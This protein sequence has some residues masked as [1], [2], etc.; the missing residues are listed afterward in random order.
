MNFRQL[1]QEEWEKQVSSFKYETYQDSPFAIHTRLV[2][3]ICVRVWN[4]AIQ[5]AAEE[6]TMISTKIETGEVTKNI[7]Y[8]NEKSFKIVID[9]DSILKLKFSYD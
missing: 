6:V 4:L 9:Q 7:I 1:I 2:E 8:H 3:Q 5:T